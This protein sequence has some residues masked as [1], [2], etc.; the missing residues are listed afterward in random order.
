M[1]LLRMLAFRPASDVVEARTLAAPASIPTNRG[2]PKEPEQEREAVAT[3]AGTEPGLSWQAIVNQLELS[4]AARQLASHCVL[5]RRQPGV[6]RLGLDPHRPFVRTSAQVEKLASALSRH[7]GETVRL[8]FEPIATDAVSPAR[9]DERATLA[10]LDCA[11]ASLET[12]P[13]VQALRERFGATL[14]PDT[15]RP[16]K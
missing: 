15:V 16:I 3:P 14:L 4:G 12:D 9:A 5:L 1:T 2:E 8:E 11:R 6:V 10:Q 7:F 13:G